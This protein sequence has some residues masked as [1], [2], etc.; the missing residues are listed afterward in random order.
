MTQDEYR[1]RDDRVEEVHDV[2]ITVP[3]K[4]NGDGPEAPLTGLGMTPMPDTGKF[5][6][7]PL[8]LLP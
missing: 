8:R 5:G 3:E 1:E 2:E 4:R 6:L 7:F